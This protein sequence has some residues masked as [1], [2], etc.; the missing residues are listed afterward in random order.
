MGTI[1]SE[2]LMDVYTND[3]LDTETI[4]ASG[5]INRFTGAYEIHFSHPPKAETGITMTYSSYQTTAGTLEIV[6]TDNAK[7]TDTLLNTESTADRQGK[8]DQVDPWI[9]RGRY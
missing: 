6:K 4:G 7:L 3:V 5:K 9:Q 1:R 8:A 2:T